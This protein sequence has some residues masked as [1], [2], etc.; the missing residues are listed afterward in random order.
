M[1]SEMGFV[2]EDK[3]GVQQWEEREAETLMSFSKPQRVREWCRFFNA[4][5][6]RSKWWV[7]VW[8]KQRRL[9]PTTMWVILEAG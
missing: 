5:R 1:K 3:S 4:G 8:E 2:K 9:C 6:I 7:W